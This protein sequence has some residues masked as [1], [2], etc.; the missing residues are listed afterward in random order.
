[1]KRVCSLLLVL[2][3]IPGCDTRAEAC[4]TDLDC[5]V[6]EQ[7]VLQTC[8]PQDEGDTDQPAEDAGDVDTDALDTG[9]VDA[10]YAPDTD[11]AIAPDA[12]DV[13]PY[14]VE[15]SAGLEH[16]CAL[17]SDATVWCWGSNSGLALGQ[18]QGMLRA[19][20]PIKLDGLDGAVQ[21][22]AG[23]G[24]TCARF[25]DGSAKCLGDS[26]GGGLG[27]GT[28]QG[29]QHPVDVLI[30]DVH[31]LGDASLHHC[32]IAGPD[33]TL[34]CWGNNDSGQTGADDD[35]TL[36]PWPVADLNGIQRVAPGE[37]HT[38]ALDSSDAVYC[39]GANDSNQ[40]GVNP[41]GPITEAPNIVEGFVP[42]N[43]VVELVAGGRHTCAREADAT[44]RCWGDN[45]SGQLGLP[46]DD[47]IAASLPV[48][49]ETSVTLSGLAAG[50][51][52]TCGISSEGHVY[53]WGANE[54][55]NLGV[56]TTS[57]YTGPQRV[58]DLNDAT[59]LSVG[60]GHSC[61]LTESDDIFCWGSNNSGQLGVDSRA[62]ALAPS[63]PVVAI[64]RD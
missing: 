2:L 12:D 30:E 64:W 61:A 15:V 44:V 54:L 31:Q 53:C 51:D 23:I 22:V 41:E 5:Y 56:G 20:T 47:P 34:Y 4:E 38:C 11:D 60:P 19:L 39:L 49:L 21:V 18:P 9:D 13:P 14:P 50:G 55:G 24:Q 58:L 35:P 26:L 33:R 1:M 6:G 43:P 25:E 62:S 27:D 59:S 17:L 48:T 42:G 40:R 57:A 63:L 29:S 8:L 46:A 28:L 3:V 52:T 16:T 37:E 36:T 10:P 45:G 7:C 32:A